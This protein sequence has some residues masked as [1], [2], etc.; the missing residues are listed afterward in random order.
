MTK[1]RIRQ[2]AGTTSALQN[3]ASNFNMHLSLTFKKCGDWKT[4]FAKQTTSIQRRRFL[5]LDVSIGPAAVL[6][7]LKRGT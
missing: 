4:Q 7:I 2:F 3:Y 6:V 1:C 5:R